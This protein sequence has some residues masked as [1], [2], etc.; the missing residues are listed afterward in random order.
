MRRTIRI[1]TDLLDLEPARF[2]R[3]V[4]AQFRFSFGKFVLA[5]RSEE[6]EKQFV[7]CPHIGLS[8]KNTNLVKIAGGRPWI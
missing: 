7:C 3:I 4:N 6:C 5:Y 1:R 8:D 2:F